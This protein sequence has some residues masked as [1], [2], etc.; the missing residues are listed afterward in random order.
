MARY[1]T[2]QQ[3]EHLARIALR[4][5]YPDYRVVWNDAGNAAL[6][7]LRASPDVLMPGDQIFIPER[8]AREERRA[9]NA[10]YRFTV[11]VARPTVRVA[12]E[13][14]LGRPLRSASSS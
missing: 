8:P 2:A 13:G 4:Y 10:R 7:D 1:H 6:R 11:K 12:L 14:L 3:G 9:T 5:G